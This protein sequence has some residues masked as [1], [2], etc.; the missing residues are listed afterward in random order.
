MEKH[1]PPRIGECSYYDSRL[2]NNGYY[3]IKNNE[4]NICACH[5]SLEKKPSE[6]ERWVSYNGIIIKVNKYMKP[7]H[8]YE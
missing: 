3:L 2:K 7:I 5:F 1:I 8:I 4:N 6:S